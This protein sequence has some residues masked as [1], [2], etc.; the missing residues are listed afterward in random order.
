MLRTAQ[1]LPPKGL[2]T[3]GFDAGCFPRRRH[4]ATGPPGSYPDRTST[5]KRRRTDDSR[6]TTYTINLLSA[7]R[8]G[9]A[10]W[11]ARAL[12]GLGCDCRAYAED[13]TESWEAFLA[14]EATEL[15]AEEAVQDIEIDDGEDAAA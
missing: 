13:I 2:S 3:L 6:S 7:G 5:G 12:C 9:K 14:E 10:H 11:V 8:T 1:L 15:A 4:A